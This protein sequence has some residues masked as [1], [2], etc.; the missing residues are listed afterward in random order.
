M[1]YE[2]TCQ[3]GLS[4]TDLALTKSFLT[5]LASSAGQGKLNAASGYAPLPSNLV[6][7]VQAS[8]SSMS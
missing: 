4:S 2:L 5:Y 8:I 3:K 6:T 7:Q 1:T